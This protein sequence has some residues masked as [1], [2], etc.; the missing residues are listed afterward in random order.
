MVARLK[1][2][3]LER[4]RA[5]RVGLG[6]LAAVDAKGSADMHD[7]V[8]EV[9]VALL[10]S[11]PFAAA[12]PGSGCRTAPSVRTRVRARRREPR[13]LVG[14]ERARLA[15]WRLRVVEAGLGGV[16]VDQAPLD[17]AGEG[18]RRAWV[19]SKGVRPRVSS[20]RRRSRARRARSAASSRT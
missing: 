8:V 16:G 15:A 11:D 20:A 10:D 3:S 17:G 19:A 1:S 18:C 12:Q 9:D 7:A 6:G 14:V 5:R 2:G 13:A 4:H